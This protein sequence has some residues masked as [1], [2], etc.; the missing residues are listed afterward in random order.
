MENLL[1]LKVIHNFIDKHT[2]DEYLS[3]IEHCTNIDHGCAEELEDNKRFFASLLM[4]DY[5]EGRWNPFSLDY[6]INPDL[7][8]I[9]E[10]RKSAVLM[11]KVNSDPTFLESHQKCRTV[12]DIRKV[13]EKLLRPNFRD[14]ED[15]RWQ[16]YWAQYM[17]IPTVHKDGYEWD[18]DYIFADTPDYWQPVPDLKC[19]I[20]DI[21]FKRG[22][23]KTQDW[24]FD[25]RWSW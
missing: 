11:N 5:A 9:N 2:F 10:I 7:H 18:I 25:D 1:D 23:F 24:K 22:M 20:G 13:R 21:I 19:H 15:R 16:Y 17:L 8:F 14:Y 12:E 6:A 4:S 3:L